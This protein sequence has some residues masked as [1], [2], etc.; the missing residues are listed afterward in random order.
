MG[1]GLGEGRGRGA[2]GSRLECGYCVACMHYSC[3]ARV[4]ILIKIKE[5][6]AA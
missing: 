2:K 6:C 1:S 4:G 5:V 3:Q